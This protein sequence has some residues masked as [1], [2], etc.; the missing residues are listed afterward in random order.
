MLVRKKK[1]IIVAGGDD[2]DDFKI[3]GEENAEPKKEDN[4]EIVDEEE[5]EKSLEVDVVKIRT[6]DVTVTYDFY[7]S[8]SRMWLIDYNEKGLP[9][10]DD[11]MKEDVMTEYRNKTCT[12]EHKLVLE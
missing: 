5:K 4:F 11:E 10:T 7:Y 3:E 1:D 2:D 9:L 6:Y 8:V 12:I